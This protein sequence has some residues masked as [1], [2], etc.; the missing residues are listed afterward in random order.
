M[1]RFGY[2]HDD[3]DWTY[4]E[5]KTPE[6]AKKEARRIFN[7][8]N[9][10]ILNGDGNEYEMNRAAA[11]RFSDGEFR[12]IGQLKHKHGPRPK[13]CK[14][15][16]KKIRCFNYEG[17]PIVLKIHSYDRESDSKTLDVRWEIVGIGLLVSHCP[18]CGSMLPLAEPKKKSPH[19]IYVPGGDGYCMTCD[20][21]VH[22]WCQCNPASA[23]YRIKT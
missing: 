20:S 9:R 8:D 10:R 17:P 14:E 4:V 3:Y 1:R 21:A 12:E 19:P 23:G 11:A 22:D 6:A 15:I 7:R 18:F 2:Y 5:A 13:C 16:N